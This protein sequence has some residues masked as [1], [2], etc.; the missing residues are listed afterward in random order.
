MCRAWASAL[1]TLHR[2]KLLRVET[3]KAKRPKREQTPNPSPERD[4]GGLINAGHAPTLV[5]PVEIRQ[6]P[7]MASRTVVDSIERVSSPP[8]NLPELEKELA[9]LRRRFPGAVFERYLAFLPQVADNAYVAPG[10]V[11]IGRV[12]L[13]ADVS[14]WPGCVVRGDI[15]RI[16]IGPRSNLQDGSVVHVGDNDPAIVGSDVVIGHRAV[17]HGCRVEAGVL[18]GIQSTILDGAVIGQGSV[19]GAGAV[20]TAGTQVPPRSLV[21]GV[22]GKIVKQLTAEDESFHRRLA[23]KYTRLAHNYRQG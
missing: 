22:P 15:N 10:A 21:L 13:G 11:I 16:E 12:L 18:L 2:H 4:R 9:V 20:V 7:P 3:T 14:V 19:V 8:D 23:A 1:R 6:A 5:T 17:V